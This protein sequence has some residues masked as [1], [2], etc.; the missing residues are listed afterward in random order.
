MIV[1]VEK[2]INVPV[3]RIVEVPVDVFVDNPITVQKVIT[4]D[5]YVDRKAEAQGKSQAKAQ[6]DDL[7]QMKAQ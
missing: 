1:P 4:K 6:E 7:L 5:V 3:E 2:I